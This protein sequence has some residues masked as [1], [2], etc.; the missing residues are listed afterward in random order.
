MVSPLGVTDP[1]GNL[2]HL[3]QL[4]IREPAWKVRLEVFRQQSSKFPAAETWDLAFLSS[5][6]KDK[7]TALTDTRT[8]N[9]VTVTLLALAGPGKTS[10]SIE[11]AG[12][13]QVRQLFFDLRRLGVW[14]AIADRFQTRGLDRNQH[15]RG[16]LAA[17]DV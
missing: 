6:A 11:T 7:A 14:F 17:P 15:C 10:Y 3:G 4:S 12:A 5:P 1:L 8:I 13:F 2:H 16:E 9:G